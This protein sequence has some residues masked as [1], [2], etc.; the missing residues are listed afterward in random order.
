MKLRIRIPGFDVAAL[1]A[2]DRKARLFLGRHA[3]SIDSVEI[4]RI[5]QAGELAHHADCEVAIALRDG[6]A[7]RVHDAANRVHRA[8]LRA[9]WRIDQRRERKRLRES[10]AVGSVDRSF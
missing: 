2:L 1:H 9:A 6:G 3:A 10:G 8:L 7:I 4:S 5:E